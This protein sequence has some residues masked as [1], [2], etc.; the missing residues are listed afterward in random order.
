MSE[1]K[2]AC[3]VCGQH[4]RCDSSQSGSVMDCPT[5]FQKIT[6]PQAPAGL[7]QKLIITGSKV[8]TAAPATTRFSV[9]AAQAAA[10]RPKK[11]PGVV[12]VIL[13]LLFMGSAAAV[14]YWATMIRPR[15]SSTVPVHVAGDSGADV[16]PAPSKPNLVAPPASDSNWGLQLET[17]VAIPDTPVAGRIHARDFIADRV[18]FQNGSLTLRAGSRGTTEFGAIINFGGVQ[19]GELSGKTINITTNAEKAARI[20]LRWKEDAGPVQKA[21]FDAGYALRLEFGTLANNRLPGKIQLCLPDTEKSYL[22]GTFNADAR[23]PK[24]KGPPRTP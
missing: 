13:I 20:T 9:A 17:N 15:Q 21:N 7:D 4:I 16:R 22:L 1:F 10:A 12:A 8:G 14:I 18:T 23:K 2:Y 19:P 6:V 5:C 24:P 3:P 11:F